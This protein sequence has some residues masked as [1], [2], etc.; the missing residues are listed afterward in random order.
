M[1]SK[2]MTNFL[3]ALEPRFYK[4]GEYIFEQGEEVDEH[5]FVINNNLAKN[6]QQT[7]GYAIGFNYGDMNS[8]YFHVKL[9][10][11]SII[12]G[13]ENLFGKRAEY[14]YKAIQHVDA[15]GIRKKDI[16]P[17]FDECKEMRNQ[18]KK[19]TL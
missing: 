7:G 8:K 19:Y 5:I 2:F 11:K 1:Y 6:I 17:I 16:K 12:C 18:M 3:R 10:P 15:Y 9:G 14:T 13:Y 4:T